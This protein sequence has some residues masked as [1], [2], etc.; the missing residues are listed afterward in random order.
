[1]PRLTDEQAQ[2]RYLA[3]VRFAIHLTKQGRFRLFERMTGD[4]VGEYASEPE[5]RAAALALDPGAMIRIKVDSGLNEKIVGG[6]TVAELEQMGLDACRK[7]LRLHPGHVGAC[8]VIPE[9][10]LRSRP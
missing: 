8:N 3:D 2:E 5:A 1:M 6:P 9:L 7:F 10:Q 4:E